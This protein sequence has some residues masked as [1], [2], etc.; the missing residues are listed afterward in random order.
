MPERRV[1]HI[2]AQVLAALAEAHANHI[3]HRD[4]KPE[5][6]MIESQRG[7]SD[8]VKVLDFGIAKILAAG[9]G[10]STLTQA[11]LVCGTPGYMSPE[12]L[13]GG[14]LDGRSDIYSMAVV[15][16]EMLT[17]RLPFEVQRPMEMLHKQLSEALVPPSVRRAAPV[18]SCLEALVMR[19][20]SP[21]REDRPG[22]AEEMREGLLASTPPRSDPLRKV[23]AEPRSTRV[24]PDPPRRASASAF[25]GRAATAPAN[26][27][28]PTPRNPA[29]AKPTT[30]S[31]AS[32]A[33]PAPIATA[34]TTGTSPTTSST[35]SSSSTIAASTLDRAVLE[36]IERRAFPFLGPIARHLLRKLSAGSVTPAEV[37]QKLATYIPSGKDR[38][39]FLEACH[40][41][42]LAAPPPG[43]PAPRTPTGV[44]WDPAL[45]ERARHDLAVHVGSLARLVVQRACSRA[46][47]PEELYE[48]LSL[49]IPGKADREHFRRSAPAPHAGNE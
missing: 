14:D 22:S 9:Q 23:G 42:P 37:C 17:G 33:I 8:S 11:G 25:S 34:P 30:R 4:L 18:S 36:R 31:S 26:Q 7:A 20:L 40:A 39:A 49:E 35:A 6:V 43:K 13:R 2:G 10:A 16:Y 15:L 48:L 46:R 5:N 12:Q 21:R 1:V 29:S 45:L 3:L 19:A 47:D 32:P 24:T 38:K 41:E 28:S 44:A 27:T